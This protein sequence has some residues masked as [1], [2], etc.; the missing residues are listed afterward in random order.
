MKAKNQEKKDEEE[1]SQGTFNATQTIC[2]C[3]KRHKV[4]Q[5]EWN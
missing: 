1:G 5:L 2:V 4:M 3:V